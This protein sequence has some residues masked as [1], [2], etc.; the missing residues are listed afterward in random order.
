MIANAMGARVIAVDIDQGKLDF[1]EAPR[2]RSRRSRNRRRR[3]AGDPRAHERWRSRIYGCARQPCYLLQLDCLPA[4]AGPPCPGRPDARRACRPAGADGAGHREGAAGQRAATACRPT[5]T[6]PCS[7]SSLPAGC[8]PQ[9]LVE[10]TI[11][12]SAAAPRTGRDGH[13]PRYGHHRY[14]RFRALTRS[15]A[16]DLP[17]PRAAYSSNSEFACPERAWG[18]CDPAHGLASQR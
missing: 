11:A 5:A 3:K 4:A 10:K 14:Q 2:R 1:A 6:E 7:T 13:L 15:P 18:P 12:L 9:L 16:G 8:R 17:G